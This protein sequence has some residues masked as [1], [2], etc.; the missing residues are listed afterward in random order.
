[1]LIRERVHSMREVH[2]IRSSQLGIRVADQTGLVKEM[3]VTRLMKLI[4]DRRTQAL[5]LQVIKQEG[6]MVMMQTRDNIKMRKLQLDQIVITRQMRLT[7]DKRT[8]ALH[9]LA[10]K[11][12]VL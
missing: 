8:Q 3:K 4:S 2:L 11:L 5:H 1:M 9:S 12:E 6:H 7:L 10:T